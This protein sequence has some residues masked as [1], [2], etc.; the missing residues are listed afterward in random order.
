VL[1]AIGPN[2]PITV[3]NTPWG[4]EFDGTHFMYVTNFGSASVSVIDTNT[5]TV[6]D[7]NGVA[8]GNAIQVGNGPT[9]ITYDPD[10]KRMYVTNFTAGTVSVI[11]ADPTSPTYNTVIA[12]IPPAGP[13]LFAQPVYVTYDPVCKDMYVT[14]QGGTTVSVIDTTTNTIIDTI[15]VQSTPIG[16]AYDPD[17]HRMYVGN[18]GSGTVS[19]ITLC[20]CPPLPTNGDGIAGLSLQSTVQQ[21]TNPIMPQQNTFN[22]SSSN[23]QQLMQ[24]QQHEALESM[25]IGAQ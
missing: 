5:N 11:D 4:I 22:M 2:N 14:N 20:D 25:L 8:A 7:A 9:D 6:I 10:L 17:K 19:V 21:N 15:T 16:I 1:V 3:E 23:A 12:T 13:P 24:Q 18:S